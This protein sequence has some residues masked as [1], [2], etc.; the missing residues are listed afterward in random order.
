MNTLHA[1]S[2]LCWSDRGTIE[3]IKELL[4]QDLVVAGSSDTVPGLLAQGSERGINA[5]NE[6]KCRAHKPYLIL[7]ASSQ[8]LSYF[9]QGDLSDPVQRLVV[10]CWPGPLTLIFKAKE[11]LSPHLVSP[12]GTVA[13]RVPNHAGLRELLG[14]FTALFSTSANLSGHFVPATVKELDP[15]LINKVACLVDD[16]EPCGE[17]VASTILDCSGPVLRLVREG[18]YPR[19]ELERMVGRL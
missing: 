18:A 12:Q 16:R 14:H 15:S 10:A 6:I 8:N 9:I 11:G 7:I 19:A 1:I 4:S 5:L 17:N 13:I 2:T 3:F